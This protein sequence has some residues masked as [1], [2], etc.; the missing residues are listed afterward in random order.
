MDEKN[1]YATLDGLRG[2]A[3]LAV[4]IF[5]ITQPSAIKPASHGYLAVDFFFALSGFVIA[6]AYE[7]RL[8]TNMTL[9]DFFVRRV[10]R[11]WPMIIAGVLIGVV[12]KATKMA[13]QQAP[14]PVLLSVLLVAGLLLVPLQIGR[15]DYPQAYPLNPAHWSLFY[16]V[17]A[18]FV[19]AA[20]LRFLATRILWLVL[21]VSGLALAWVSYAG[22]GLLPGSMMSEY[23]WGLSRVVF[24]FSAGVLIYRH[25]PAISLPIPL[26]IGLLLAALCIPSPGFT[27]AYDLACAFVVFPLVVAAGA[28]HQ[29]RKAGIYLLG[30]R[31][32]YPI[33]A[34]H[35]PFFPTFAHVIRSY[36]LTGAREAGALCAEFLLVVALAYLLL[37]FYDEPVRKRLTDFTRKR[38][39]LK[40]ARWRRREPAE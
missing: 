31:I 27:W 38:I 28:N 9:G 19:Y 7:R 36:G 5:H 30:G 26:I 15:D 20:S 24:S 11:L 3:A 34:I 39:A 22:D 2:V 25:R 23:P 12:G 16:E 14:D 13:A 35:Y 40:A 4:V 18:N 1:H 21:G 8:T 10:I 32:S 6:A 37:R 33:Y 17:A 29:P